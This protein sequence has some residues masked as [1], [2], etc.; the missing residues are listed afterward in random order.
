MDR[1]LS[2]FEPVEQEEIEQAFRMQFGGGD[3]GIDVTAVT[4]HLADGRSVSLTIEEFVEAIER[5]IIERL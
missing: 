1:S 4:V 2:T 3:G 5:K